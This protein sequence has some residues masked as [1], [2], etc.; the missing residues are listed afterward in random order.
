MNQNFIN[1]F[2]DELNTRCDY[3]NTSWQCNI[4][5]M[6]E[7]DLDCISNDKICYS[8]RRIITK[9]RRKVQI[10]KLDE[11]ITALNQKRNELHDEII[12]MREIFYKK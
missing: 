4:Q 2:V 10:K 7:D 12:S 6:L 3:K 11:I 1:I 8:C 5:I 9:Y